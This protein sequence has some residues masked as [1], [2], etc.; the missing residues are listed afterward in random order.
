MSRRRAFVL[1]GVHLLFAV[2]LAHWLETG[3]TMSPLEPSEAMEFS[4][5]SVINAGFIFFGLTILSTLFLGRWFCGWAC[6]LVA[7]QD[8]SSWLLSRVGIKPKPLSSRLLAWVPAVAALYMFLWPLVYRLG[9]G[10]EL[11]PARL[12]LTKSEFWE[13]FPPLSVALLTFFV[14]GGLIVYFLGSKGFCTYACPYG[15]IF[16]AVDRLAPGR[17]RVSD[18]CEGCAHCTATCTSNVRVHEEV[19][20]HGMVVDPGCMKCMDCVSVCPMNALSFGFGKPAPGTRPARKAV[21]TWKEEGLL[22]TLFL[23]GLAV[24][25]GLYGSVP[26]LL[27]LGLAAILAYLLFLLIRLFLRR[28]LSLG[29]KVLK[30][31]GRLTGTGRGFLAGMALVLLFT[32]HSAMVR[33]HDVQSARVFESTFELQERALTQGAAAEG[34][35]LERA[36]RG[37]A[38]AEFVERYGLVLMPQIDL[39]LA[40]FALLEGDDAGF[41]ER[42]GSF[43]GQS[44]DNPVLHEDLG[45]FYQGRGRLDEAGAAYRRALELHPSSA[46][47]DRLAQLLWAAR[48]P[49]EAIEVYEEAVAALPDSSDL[50]FNLAI[51]CELTGREDEALAAFREVLRLDP[52]R[53]AAHE[54]L[55]RGH[56][57]KREFERAIPH[58]RRALELAP[59]SL[60]S[61]ELLIIAL[62]ETGAVEEASGE[63]ARLRDQGTL[64]PE[65]A[66]RYEQ[67]IGEYG[68]RGR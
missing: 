42:L 39:R 22:A 60:D 26:F 63:V 18:A 2:H 20:E 65:A 61:L 40:W 66:A 33:Y 41:E 44:P 14:C 23:V 24:Y 59:T 16:G 53:V 25:R 45:R 43:L 30:R 31:A 62:L 9:S 51:A 28:D 57:A 55:G 1:F 38:H 13:T 68:R 12:A 19:R 27:A 7:L 58:L 29:K 15:A 67:L 8:L 10:G 64:P 56:L 37:K 49:G 3:S 21:Y 54:N 52:E 46:L 11:A 34:A 47:Y 48:A 35:D 4:K 5:R 32:G 17:I 36:R 50:H 6:H